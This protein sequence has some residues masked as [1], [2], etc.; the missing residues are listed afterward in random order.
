MLDIIL[1]IVSACIFLNQMIQTRLLYQ[2]KNHDHTTKL[3]SL[4]DESQCIILKRSRTEIFPIIYFHYFN[5]IIE[6][7]G[8][9]GI[10]KLANTLLPYRYRKNILIQKFPCIIIR[11]RND[12]SLNNHFLINNFFVNVV[13]QSGKYCK[14]NL[15]N[16]HILNP[17]IYS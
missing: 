16:P 4:T 14:L 10:L 3:H 5:H 13:F 17:H 12:K 15:L 9:N 2:L 6:N 7:T 8:S 1:I 11:K